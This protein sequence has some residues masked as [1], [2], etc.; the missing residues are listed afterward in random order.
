MAVAAPEGGIF[1]E[2]ALL[3]IETEILGF[4]VLVI[5]V[6]LAQR[7][8]ADIAVLEENL[9]KRLAAIGGIGVE[10][11]RLPHF[12]GGEALGKFHQLPEI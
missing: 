1:L 10:Y 9:I 5:R 12:I 6:D 7:E 11:L 8:L 4:L 3:Q 2:E